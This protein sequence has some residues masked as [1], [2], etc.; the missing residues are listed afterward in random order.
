MTPLREYTL[1]VV[2]LSALGGTIVFA[3]WRDVV[4]GPVAAQIAVP[5]QP[6]MVASPDAAPSAS[7]SVDSAPV[8]SPAYTV[9]AGVDANET[10]YDRPHGPS[11]PHRERYFASTRGERP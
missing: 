11:N 8:L 6:G 5:S 9:P 1:I 7:A 3:A 2:T 4:P 10:S